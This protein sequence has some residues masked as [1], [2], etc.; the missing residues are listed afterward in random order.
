MAGRAEA[1]RPAAPAARARK[2]TRAS[3]GAG[4]GRERI[5]RGGEGEIMRPRLRRHDSGWS[6]KKNWMFSSSVRA[7]S[8]ERADL[9][10]VHPPFA[11]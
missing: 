6:E 11:Y 4:G 8:A 7:G 9:E 1:T 10:R 3:I 2:R 5:W